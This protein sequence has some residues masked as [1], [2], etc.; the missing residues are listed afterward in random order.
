[1]VWIDATIRSWSSPASPA[2]GGMAQNTELRIISG[3]STGLRM[4]MA[5]P[6]W[7]PPTASTAAAVVSVNSSMLA[8][9]P[10]PAER[11]ETDATISAYG[12]GT[13]EETAWTI[14]T[15]AWPPQVIMLTFSASRLNDRLTG[16]HR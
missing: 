16:G 5:L 12:T 10:G 2:S 6:R 15:V 13:M 3:G 4:M 9:V 1:M 7:A 11:L 14:G 8:L